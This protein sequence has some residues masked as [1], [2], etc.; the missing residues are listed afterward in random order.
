[1]TLTPR[2]QLS[3]TEL[4]PREV[5]AADFHTLPVLP[6]AD[7]AVL[8]NARA[9]AALGHTL[10]RRPDAFMKLGDSN[11]STGGLSIPQYLNPLGDAG[12]NPGATGLANYGP[13]I[14]DTLAAFQAQITPLG[15]NSFTRNSTAA[16]PGFTMPSVLS[17]VAGEIAS[18]NAGIALVMIGTN[19][20]AIFQNPELYR[21]M[22]TQLVQTLTSAGIVPVLSTLPDHADNAGLLPVVFQYNQVIADVGGQFRVPVWNLYDRLAPL[23]HEGLDPGGVHLTASPNGGGSFFTSDLLYGQ[24]ARN[25]DALMILDWFRTEVF[26]A[27]PVDPLTAWTPLTADRPVFAVG[28]DAGQAPTV[29]IHDAAT[30]GLVSR[31]LALPADFTGGVRVATA[32]VNGDGFTDVIVTPGAG[33]GPVVTV[34]N[35]KDGSVLTSFYAFDPDFRN[36]FTVAAGDLDGDGKA[37]IV[38]GAGNG[39]GPQV[40]VY[41][42]GDFTSV[43]QF[44]AYDESFRGG[45]S[46]AVG[47]FA[48]VG[49]AIVAGSGVG[50]GP[51]VELFRY[52]SV[53]PDR[54]F[55]A[56]DDS[57][58]DGVNVAAGDLTGDGSDVLITAPAGGSPDVRV[59][60]LIEGLLREFTTDPAAASGA[61]L[62]VVHGGEKSAARLLVANGSGD[63]TAIRAYDGLATDPVVVFA[64][65]GRAYGLYVG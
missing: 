33:G 64:D 23:P 3:I 59:F 58:R 25:L 2:V 24:N 39:G 15:E 50:G 56:F 49:P 36:G 34:F 45:V 8:D 28:R 12:Y 32:D 26:T 35:G 19:D 27:A 6:T 42:G 16:Y 62:A 29:E 7:P 51:Q 13:S 47:N 1:M 4:E 53:V 40:G 9:I 57:A 38:V 22:L 18:T 14:V 17:R 43:A 31:F 63:A 55:F 30:G 46:V 11:T 52:G 41:H 37:E 54:A 21:T 44:F 60:D 65:P 10:G 61:R 48:G 20:L 5:P